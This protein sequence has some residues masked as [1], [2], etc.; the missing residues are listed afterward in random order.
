MVGGIATK[1]YNVIVANKIFLTFSWR[2]ILRSETIFVKWISFKTEEKLLLFHLK[3]SY[4]TIFLFSRYSSFC[5]YIS[6]YVGK[7]SK[8]IKPCT[9]DK[10]TNTID[11]LIKISKDNM[12]NIF[13]KN[14]AKN[15]V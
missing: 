7:I 5:S 9:I 2:P 11:I 10:Q 3:R 1:H 14:D 8:F 4:F 13:L 12:R 15:V 6:D